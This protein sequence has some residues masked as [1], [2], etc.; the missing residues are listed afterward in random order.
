MWRHP[1]RP[2][3]RTVAALI[4]GDARVTGLGVVSDATKRQW[5]LRAV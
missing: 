1:V 5:R 3:A 4:R 2:D